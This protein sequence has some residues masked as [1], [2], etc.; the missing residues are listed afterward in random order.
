MKRT[1]LFL[2]I[3]CLLV[4]ATAQA[5]RPPLGFRMGYTSW[6]NVHQFHFGGQAKLG[7]IFPNVALTPNLEMGFGDNVT[8]ITANGDLAYRVT[9]L[10]EAPWGPYVGGGLSFIYVDYP[11]IGSD[12]NLGLSALVG[13][14]YALDN[15]NE[16]F[17]E[18]RLGVMDSPGLKLTV[19]YTFF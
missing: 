10:A 13:T 8:V 16:V 5:Q 19:G 17:G 1:V 7:D 12:T 15:G 14:T 11:V 4:A 6:E 3:A 18:L 9:E 2:T